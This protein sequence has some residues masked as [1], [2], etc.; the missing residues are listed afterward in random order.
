MTPFLPFFTRFGSPR[1][2]RKV[3][4]LLQFDAIQEPL[5][6]VDILHGEAQDLV[7]NK[8]AALVKGDEAKD[9][10]AGLGKDILSVLCELEFLLIA[11]TC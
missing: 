1:F 4:D 3:L 9:G 7:R 5:S 8:K 11:S 2:R 10:E 6:L